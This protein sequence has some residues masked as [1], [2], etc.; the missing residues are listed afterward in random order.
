MT[1]TGAPGLAAGL[2]AK[3]CQFLLSGALLNPLAGVS[4]GAGSD[5]GV[6]L[7]MGVAAFAAGGVGAVA[8]APGAYHER[9]EIYDLVRDAK[10]T[11]SPRFCGTGTFTIRADGQLMTADAFKSVI[12]GFRNRAPVRLQQV[13]TVI[14]EHPQPVT[15]GH[16]EQHQAQ[17]VDQPCEQ[18]RVD[19]GAASGHEDRAELLVDEPVAVLIHEDAA[20]EPQR[21]RRAAVRMGQPRRPP[22]LIHQ[23]GVRADSH[24]GPVRC[25]PNA[26]HPLWFTNA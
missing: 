25:A 8:G 10:I 1:P 24:G 6:G 17:L 20:G 7:R 16:G 19:E 4:S 2:V 22:R 9:G 11:G 13:A 14:G 15:H 18:Q 23:V 12:L 5:A 3:D 26:V 21:E